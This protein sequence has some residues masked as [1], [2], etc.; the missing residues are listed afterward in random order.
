MTT[1]TLTILGFALLATTAV[2]L[3]LAGRA[4]RFGVAPLGDLTD[5][6]RSRTA[7]RFALVLAWAWLGWHL[8]AR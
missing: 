3:Y 4:H 5:A 6:L 1:R 2:V 7:V 8:L